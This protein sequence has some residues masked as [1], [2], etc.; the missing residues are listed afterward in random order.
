MSV[1]ELIAK[2]ERGQLLSRDEQAQLVQ[3]AHLML[4]TLL[5]LR[6]D[7]LG[8]RARTSVTATLGVVNAEG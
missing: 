6:Q 5:M 3:H 2:Y 4:A 7:V 1:P 8:L